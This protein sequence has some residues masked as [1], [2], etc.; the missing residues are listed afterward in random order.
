VAFIETALIC[1]R[2]C[3]QSFEL[4]NI[5]KRCGGILQDSNPLFLL[6]SHRAIL[7]SCLL[8]LHVAA[9]IFF[10]YFLSCACA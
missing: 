4:M 2:R 5:L 3:S 6:A 9:P 10:K 7:F 1:A 8:A